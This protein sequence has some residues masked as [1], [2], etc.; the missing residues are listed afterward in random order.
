LSLFAL[1]EYRQ[2]M[3]AYEV[4]AHRAHMGET[5]NRLVTAVVMDARGIYASDTSQAAATFGEGGLDSLESMEGLLAQWVPMVPAG[6]KASFENLLE[7]SAEF[8]AFRSETVRLAAEV[9]PKA[10]NEQGNNEGNRNNRKAYQAEIDAIVNADITEL[11]AVNNALDHFGN[12]IFAI[13]A[14][15]TLLGAGAGAAFGLYLGRRQLS[16]PILDLTASM[17]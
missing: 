9:G 15:V 6:Q 12:S 16:A 2:R 11:A 17:K 14:A 1:S 4:A 13:V 3:D 10:A 8:K 5:L 7:R